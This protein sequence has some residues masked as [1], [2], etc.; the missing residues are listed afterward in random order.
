[1]PLSRLGLHGHSTLATAT[2]PHH[3]FRT[4]YIFLKYRNSLLLD[5]NIDYTT[6]NNMENITYSPWNK[7]TNVQQIRVHNVLEIHLSRVFIIDYISLMFVVILNMWLIYQIEMLFNL[8]LV[9]IFFFDNTT[10]PFLY[11]LVNQFSAIFDFISVQTFLNTG[12]DKIGI[13]S[14]YMYYYNLWT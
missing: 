11:Q 1:M 4:W 12:L 6:N 9:S 7:S 5:G 14:V 10:R 3:F 8:I 2:Q 13:S